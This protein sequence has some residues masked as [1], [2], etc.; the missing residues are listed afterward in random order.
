VALALGDGDEAADLAGP[1]SARSR[2]CAATAAA[3]ADTAAAAAAT[4]A[5]ATTAAAAATAAAATTAVENKASRQAGHIYREED[6]PPSRQIA[7]WC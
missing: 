4:A 5:A 1:S 2:S 3:R 7:I 6:S